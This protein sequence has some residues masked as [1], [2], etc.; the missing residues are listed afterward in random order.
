LIIPQCTYCAHFNS[1]TPE[2]TCRAFPEGI[3][4][5]IFV[6]GADH[7]KPYPGDNGIQFEPAD[8]E[9]AQL[10]IEPADEAA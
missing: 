9:A 7:S 4:S 3:P 10:S 2:A 8:A 1:E 6:K 5:A